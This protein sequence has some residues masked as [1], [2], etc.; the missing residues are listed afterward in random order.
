MPYDELGN[1]FNGDDES[2]LEQFP[3]YSD[4]KPFSGFTA[5]K[6]KEGINPKTVKSVLQGLGSAGESLARGAVSM[7]LGF[8]ADIFEGG[9]FILNELAN[10][11]YN[12]EGFRTENYD[13]NNKLFEMGKN[14]FT[15]ENLLK[16][17]K[18]Y[19]PEFGDKDTNE[20][21][22][23]LGGMAGFRALPTAFKLEEEALEALSKMPKMARSERD[24]FVMDYVNRKNGITPEGGSLGAK[25]A[26]MSMA[27]EKGAKTAGKVARNV[28]DATVGNY[29]RG[30][31][32]RASEENPP[33]GEEENELF[34]QRQNENYQSGVPVMAV[35]RVNEGKMPFAKP[36]AEGETTNSLGQDLNSTQAEQ[37]L[38]EHYPFSPSV[39]QD[40]TA[41]GFRQFFLG[42][43]TTP[44]STMLFPQSD[45]SLNQ[46]YHAFLQKRFDE[47]YPNQSIY[48]FTDAQK[49][50]FDE[51]IGKEY[52]NNEL[53]GKPVTIQPRADEPPI[54]VTYPD[55]DTFA[56]RKKAVD[57]L[58]SDVVPQFMQRYMASEKDPLL[59]LAR[60][61]ITVNPLDSY[62]SRNI[63]NPYVDTTTRRMR[64]ES[65]I[66]EEGL[67]R[68]AYLDAKTAYDDVEKTA[69]AL[70]T[71]VLDLG[72]QL[73][74]SGVAPQSN[75]QWVEIRNQHKKLIKDLE[76]KEE[77]LRNASTANAYEN[78]VD[79]YMQ[80]RT[81][82]RYIQKLPVNERQYQE[83]NLSNLL[84]HE[85]VY[86]ILNADDMGKASG[87]SDFVG[88]LIN[89]ILTGVYPIIDTRQKIKNPDGTKTNNENYGLINAE[90]I[91]NVNIPDYIRKITKP[92]LN[93]EKELRKNFQEMN[94]KNEA[95][96]KGFIEK[97]RTEFPES[98]DY[99][100]I[101]PVDVNNGD[102]TS[103]EIRQQ[104][105][106]TCWELDHCSG[107]GAQGSG[108]EIH[109]RRKEE[110]TY[111]PQR[112][113]FSNAKY[114]GSS[115]DASTHINSII[116]GYEH[117]ID[118]RDK[119]TGLPVFTAQLKPIQ[120]L[121]S[122]EINNIIN[123]LESALPNNI[124]IVK[125]FANDV[126]FKELNAYGHYANPKKINRELDKLITKYPQFAN[127]FS[128]VKIDDKNIMYDISY[129][130][131]YKDKM[132]LANN[133]GHPYA[134]QYRDDIV[135][136]LN[137]NQ[138]IINK[139]SH[140]YL[141]KNGIL[142]TDRGE[143]EHALGQMQIPR[144]ESLLISKYDFNK[145]FVDDKEVQGVIDR[146]KLEIPKYENLGI[147]P[148][149]LGDYL[150]QSKVDLEKDKYEFLNKSLLSISKKQASSQNIIDAKNYI[151]KN[152]YE[153][154]KKIKEYAND[155]YD[156][157]GWKYDTLTKFSHDVEQLLK[158]NGVP[159]SELVNVVKPIPFN[160]TL[161]N[162]NRRMQEMGY[163]D[164]TNPTE[165]Y[166]KNIAG[167]ISANPSAYQ[168]EHL[169]EDELKKL[170]EHIE[171]NGF[172]PL[173]QESVDKK[174]L[175]TALGNLQDTFQRNYPSTNFDRD[176]PVVR[177]AIN[178]Q[179]T[180]NAD[181]YSDELDGLSVD[182]VNA[183]MEHITNHGF[184]QNIQATPVP[185]DEFSQ[186]LQ[187]LLQNYGV[188]NVN[189]TPATIAQVIRDAPA[190][191]GL[192][193]I[194]P[195]L[196][197]P[198]L[199]HI[200]QFG[201]NGVNPQATQAITPYQQEANNFIA[202]LS[203]EPDVQNIVQQT[204]NEITRIA[205]TPQQV[206]AALR[207]EANNPIRGQVQLYFR[208]LANR[209]EALL[210]AQGHKDGGYIK[211][212]RPM[213]RN[214][215]QMRQELMMS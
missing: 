109:H 28:E 6:L 40:D 81:K 59:D 152:P 80:K 156:T 71:Q 116:G 30:K 160:E 37:M 189:D 144:I 126:N 18:R 188:A 125:E 74:N 29:Q 175:M 103:E 182:E 155:N 32:R 172:A 82:E 56:E 93:K 70:S 107:R 120:H 21:V 211:R 17:Q 202:S 10:P 124:D 113:A 158:N 133:D 114:P 91:R 2:P 121:S 88:H 60:E 136:W 42:N 166:R 33:R 208:S 159:K 209:L 12:E 4:V 50:K 25:V 184:N 203:P 117:N 148:Q 151:T 165:Q 131:G 122:Y 176:D 55:Y 179:L 196:R 1:F 90:N 27:V 106:L 173:P 194:R 118:F 154:I 180:H 147:Q 49:K 183:L 54:E 210:P 51:Q 215:Q 67:T 123:Q 5:D 26:E 11:R 86:D 201:F 111:L 96:A 73:I 115:E 206:I 19:T 41:N 53:A 15:T 89:D 163:L 45:S 129:F 137:K 181:N 119:N 185:Q 167:R 145:R 213:A 98:D 128:N 34:R 140:E 200:E 57:L 197:Q 66:P 168:V 141:P 190:T 44:E 31:V 161:N 130:M 22:E 58:V 68:Q 214:V 84:P 100:K 157:Q 64:G 127:E 169:S 77:A 8:P 63:E 162:L 47:L 36:L 52:I 105:S 76:K 65:G 79:A 193:D 48:D 75:P 146:K 72:H 177:N 192:N 104:N 212:A 14:P 92:R 24:R 153:F 46:K 94:E 143:F 134:T 83:P 87:Y 186:A 174:K 198:L 191:F 38:T 199:Q 139:T 171:T 187:S 150:R 85:S 9:K 138:N 195:G 95:F 20:F 112:I 149:I 207:Y 97:Y 142:D 101:V 69:S 205:Q 13:P 23:G 35:R 108:K 3:K 16:A 43:R 102:F 135:E 178:F 7:P 110:R 99:N 132:T 62:F 204:Y 78:D 170:L 39:T 164:L 61:G